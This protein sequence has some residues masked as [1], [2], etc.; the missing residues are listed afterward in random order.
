M[1]RII[2]MVIG[3]LLLAIGVIAL[4]G[5]VELLRSAATTEEIAQGFLVPASLFAIG[6]FAIWMS[7]KSR[8]R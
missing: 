5:A 1:G 2:G 4:I 8:R 6:G 3:G 7:W